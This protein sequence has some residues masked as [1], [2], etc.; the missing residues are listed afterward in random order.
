MPQLMQLPAYE[1]PR[2]ALV[3][4]RPINDAIDTNRANA[5]ANRR[6][7]MEGERLSMDK[8][9]LQIAEADS[10][11]QRQMRQVQ[12]WAGLAKVIDEMP[13]G[14]QKA[15]AAQKFWSSNPDLASHA[16]QFGMNVN[17]P[18]VWKMI[19]AEAGKYDPLGEKVK[20]AE[21]EKSRAQAGLAT[22]QAANLGSTDDIREFQ[23]AQKN[24]FRG[25]FDE[26]MVKK[27]EGS[28]KF[29]LNPIPFQKSD[30]TIGYMVPNTAGGS[31]ELGIPGGGTAMP[32]AVSVQTPTEVITRDQFGREIGRERKDI[33]GKER[34]EEIGKA[35][36]KAVA[37]LPR[38]IDN[39][40]LA[41]KT[42]E[43]IRQHPGKSYAV[44]AVSVLPGIP[45]TQQR[46]FI[47]LS[48]QLEGKTF[49]EAFNSLRGGG[50]ITEVEGA[51]ATQ[52]IARLSRAQ[53][54]DDYDKALSDLEDVIYRGLARARKAT[55]QSSPAAPAA[56]DGWSAVR[57]K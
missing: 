5:L 25:G 18:H 24:G 50:Q 15:D 9:R 29:G 49:L 3:D 45:G 51:K 36:G 53:G 8:R 21:L 35:Q 46:G 16:G 34:E 54:V 41:L 56:N 39:A 33:A 40:D 13:D 17:H 7:D 6:M 38:Q 26:W 52:A 23:F 44:G 32:K 27:R 30:G 10:A 55:G 31:Q 20:L 14:P 4:F 11:E 19:Q 37:D 12:R 22:A 43:Q 1:Y 42:I 47:E 28:T 2:N 57:V 48:K